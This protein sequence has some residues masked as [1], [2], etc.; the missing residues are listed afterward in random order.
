M[1]AAALLLAASIGLGTCLNAILNRA[2]ARYL[3][4]SELRQ[5]WIMPKSLGRM[6]R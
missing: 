2:T 3:R 1:I 4:Q 6:R 5:E